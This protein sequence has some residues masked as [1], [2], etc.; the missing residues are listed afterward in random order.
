MLYGD[1]T[2]SSYRPLN[3]GAPQGSVLGPLIFCEYVND[4]S[5]YLD[6][7]ISRILYADNLQI[8]PQCHLNDLGLRWIIPYYINDLPSVASDILI[9]D[10]RVKFSLSI[11]NLG[12]LLENRLCWKEHV[13]EFHKRANTLM[14]R[15]HRLRA[16]STLKLRKHLI[17]VLLWPLVD[18][19][20]LVYCNISKDQDIILERIINTGIRYIYGVTNFFL[21]RISNRP[22]RGGV[23]PRIVPKHEHVFLANSFHITTAYIWK[24]LPLNHS[25]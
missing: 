23:K 13:N 7:R 24:S 3:T 14:Y 18:Y 9:G 6:P 10:T 1:G 19:C 25:Q 4:I 5:L 11:R 16:S 2:T 21:R 12:L 15:L 22:I 20:S 8:Y 17:Q